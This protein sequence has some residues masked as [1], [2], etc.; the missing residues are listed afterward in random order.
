M[1][2][3][4]D[5]SEQ[6]ANH[7]AGELDDEALSQLEQQILEDDQIFES[8]LAVETEMVDAWIRGELPRAQ[9]TG[10][11]E[12]LGASTR[13]QNS[14]QTTLALDARA[15]ADSGESGNARTWV[16]SMRKR[17]RAFALALSL[18]VVA[19]IAGHRAY[20]INELETT[21]AALQ[22]ARTAIQQAQAEL[23]QA[24]EINNILEIELARAEARARQ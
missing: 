22:A 2:A 11:T 9:A 12:L 6:F 13:L 16:A 18:G 10:L 21:E 17:W 23:Q 3:S 15:P 1:S 7:L 20:I 19:G 5:Q 4:K 8:C 14:F 24:E